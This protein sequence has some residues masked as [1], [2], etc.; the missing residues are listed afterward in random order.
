M[1][2]EPLR[3]FWLISIIIVLTC[4]TTTGW[5]SPSRVT[6]I[7]GSDFT[8]AVVMVDAGGGKLAIKKDGSGTRFTFVVNDKTQFEGRLRSLTDVKKGDSLT[9]QYR[10][11]G[12]QYIALKIAPQE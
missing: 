2:S 4:S 11:V 3:F 6:A 1:K 9:V 8:G 10:V 7:E 5:L 12:S